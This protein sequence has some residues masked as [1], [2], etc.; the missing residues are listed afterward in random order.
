[1]VN[2]VHNLVAEIETN[3]GLSRVF[4]LRISSLFFLL[5]N[6]LLSI[7]CL[8]K[9]FPKTI[10]WDFLTASFWQMYIHSDFL[11][12]H[13]LFGWTKRIFDEC[14]GSD[15]KSCQYHNSIQGFFSRKNYS[16]NVITD[17]DNNLK[18]QKSQKMVLITTYPNATPS[19]SWMCFTVSL[20][21]SSLMS[22]QITVAFNFPN[23]YAIWRPIP[24]P[25]PVT[26][27]TSPATGLLKI[28]IV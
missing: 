27:A 12:F 22:T 4:N 26:N 28:K 13:H 5:H 18:K 11:L 6:I 10:R 21:V 7:Y 23:W 15:T 1:M 19:V 14:S 3:Q 8:I 9:L 17:L 16:W 20:F 24:C 2:A 25:A